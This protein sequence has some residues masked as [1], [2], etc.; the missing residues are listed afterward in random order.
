MN[1][2]A[3]GPGQTGLDEEVAELVWAMNKLPGIETTNSCS[4]HG[5]RPFLI[6]FVVTDYD[7]RGLLLLSR[8]LSHNYYPFWRH[9]R[10]RL[11]HMDVE[12]QVCWVLEGGVGAPTFRAAEAMAA[13]INAHVE[14]TV[15]GYNI[16]TG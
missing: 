8:L 7:A 2:P 16:L 3:I 10:V 9:L 14:G 4:G 6:W 13:Q 11:D 5:E 1:G 15:T 12:P